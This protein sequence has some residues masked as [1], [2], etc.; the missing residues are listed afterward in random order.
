MLLFLFLQVTALRTKYAEKTAIS[1]GLQADLDSQLSEHAALESSLRG[2]IQELEPQ[3][4]KVKDGL[5]RLMKRLDHMEWQTDLMNKKLEEMTQSS[6]M[7]KKTRE[8]V[9]VAIE[10]LK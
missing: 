5:V 1:K 2:K 6:N 9:E 3:H 10:D 7:I 8:K 4:A